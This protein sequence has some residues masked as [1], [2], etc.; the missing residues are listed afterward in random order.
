[1]WH[2]GLQQ[3]LIASRVC[4]W[5]N[6]IICVNND[7]LISI[8]YFVSMKCVMKHIGSVH[9]RGLCVLA[10]ICLD[11]SPVCWNQGRRSVLG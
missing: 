6:I 1:M 10:D 3:L 2:I 7:M 4:P 5:D 8:V 11:D 9:G